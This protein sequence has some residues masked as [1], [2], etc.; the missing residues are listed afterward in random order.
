MMLR[1]RKGFF[2]TKRNYVHR[3]LA[4]SE[5]YSP[6]RKQAL[7]VTPQRDT[8]MTSTPGTSRSSLLTKPILDITRISSTETDNA[9]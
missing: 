8:I 4:K 6:P 1:P 3:R 7:I 2:L 5:G 9:G